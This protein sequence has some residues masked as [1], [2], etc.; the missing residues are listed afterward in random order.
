MNSVPPNKFALSS[1]VTRG[2]SQGR[3]KLS[4]TGGNWPP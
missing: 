3:A 4:W 2:L 1:G